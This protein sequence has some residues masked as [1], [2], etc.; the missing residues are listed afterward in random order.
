MPFKY[1][2]EISLHAW[3]ALYVIIET[4]EISHAVTIQEVWSP[5]LLA[6]QL[7]VGAPKQT[8]TFFCCFKPH[9][10]THIHLLMTTPHCCWDWL[11]PFYF[12]LSCFS[13]SNS[14]SRCASWD[15]PIWLQIRDY[16][17]PPQTS[18]V[19]VIYM[20]LCLSVCVYLHYVI[21]IYTHIHEM[22]H[23]YNMFF[24]WYLWE[25][26]GTTSCIRV[27]AF[28]LLLLLFLSF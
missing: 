25:Q 16:N 17:K 6:S 4:A 20:H 10:H 3:C 23:S 24:W 9:T 21:H 22:V 1:T 27:C 5:V 11:L 13:L 19:Y 15:T 26:R 14:K 8:H 12:S 7:W 2:S 28:A 18:L